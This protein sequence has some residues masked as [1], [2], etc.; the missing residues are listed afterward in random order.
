MMR[1]PVVYF[2]SHLS[3]IILILIMIPDLRQPLDGIG[4]T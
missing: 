4:I 3:I 2:D 1:M